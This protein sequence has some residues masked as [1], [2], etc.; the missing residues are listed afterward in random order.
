MNPT[1]DKSSIAKIQIMVFVP[2]LIILGVT[3]AFFWYEAKWYHDPFL[4]IIYSIFIFGQIIAT[5]QYPSI[6][7]RTKSY[8][9]NLKL[10]ETMSM[11]DLHQFEQEFEKQAKSSPEKELIVKWA[12]MGQQGDY[13][14]AQ[15]LL[16]NARD[17]QDVKTHQSIGFH[18]LLNRLTL[19]MGF[20][21][22]LIGLVQTFPPMKKAILGLADKDGQMQF[23][24]DI[25]KAIDGDE[26]AILTT[27]VATAL[28]ILVESLSI[29][30]LEKNYGRLD[31]YFSQLHS[32]F[33]T[34]MRPI[35]QKNYSFEGAQM[36]LIEKHQQTEESMIQAQIQMTENLTEFAKV[37]QELKQQ[38]SQLHQ[39]QHQVEE[40][41]DTLISHEEL[42]QQFLQTKDQASAP[43]SL[44]AKHT[45]TK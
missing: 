25:A 27:L 26:Y 36:S 23:I 37:S 40:K 42:Y 8:Q 6:L 33:I 20:L 30:L 19:K 45:G 4:V 38:I 32:W 21:G 3:L 29:F 43:S 22:T 7:K 35:I 10:L 41:V 11:E 12:Q 2:A 18:T 39:V 24:K 14:S 16:D 34:N 17:I 15:S 31:T 13:H 9:Y 5:F 28:S 44:R 1:S